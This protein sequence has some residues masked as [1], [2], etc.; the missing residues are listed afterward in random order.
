MYIIICRY[1]VLIFTIYRRLSGKEG[2]AFSLHCRLNSLTGNTFLSEIN[3][4]ATCQ[5]ALPV[6]HTGHL[7]V[8]SVNREAVSPVHVSPGNPVEGA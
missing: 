7:V 2:R 8:P 6:T 5:L 1:V 4:F 3:P